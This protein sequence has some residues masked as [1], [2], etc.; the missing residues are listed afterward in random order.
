VYLDAIDV[1]EARGWHQGDLY[2]PDNSCCLQGAMREAV[3]QRE[4]TDHSI[5]W[6]GLGVERLVR[7]MGFDS[8]P[9]FNDDP[10]TTYEDVVL[11]LKRAHEM[12][13]S[14]Q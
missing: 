4:V 13:E 11:L 1:L 7:Q 9:H 3:M 8:V 2:G 14:E 6:G 5:H 10:N 12:W